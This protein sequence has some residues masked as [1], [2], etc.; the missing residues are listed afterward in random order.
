MWLFI[1]FKHNY[2]NDKRL[3]SFSSWCY[4]D[5]KSIDNELVYYNDCLFIKC[6]HCFEWVINLLCNYIWSFN[7]IHA[8]QGYFRS[9]THVLK[10]TD[11]GS[12]NLISKGVNF[13]IR[14]R[15]LNTIWS[16]TNWREMEPEQF[17]HKST[18]LL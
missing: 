15:L 14:G 9:R 17:R 8:L 1:G 2:F 11:C 5:L 12:L 18:N 6:C 3:G 4:N 13:V 10:C 7:Y 16:F